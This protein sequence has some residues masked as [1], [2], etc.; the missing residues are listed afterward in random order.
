MVENKHLIF[1][2]EYCNKKEDFQGH[3][4]LIP[5]VFWNNVICN[6]GIFFNGFENINSQKLP[7]T[8]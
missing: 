7:K 2:R 4:G 8:N 3:I 6:N 1:F 5:Y